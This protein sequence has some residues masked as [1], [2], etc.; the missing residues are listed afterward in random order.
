MAL[1][2]W[3]RFCKADVTGWRR[4]P[5]HEPDTLGAIGA[6]KMNAKQ[7]RRRIENIEQRV[8]PK[9]DGSCTLEELCRAIWRQDRAS[10]KN[11]VIDW[12][13]G[14]FFIAQ[15]EREDAGL[16]AV[17]DTRRYGP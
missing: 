17:R 14:N 11:I 6:S 7:F 5:A 13:E 3:P 12:P 9:H 16:I 8:C 15:F 2:R 1:K 4:P 10:L